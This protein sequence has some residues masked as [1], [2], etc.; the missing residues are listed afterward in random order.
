MTLL[1]QTKSK[2]VVGS[3]HFS[4]SS[5]PLHVLGPVK[6]IVVPVIVVTV[7]GGAFVVRVHES[8]ITGHDSDTSGM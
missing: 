7:I 8:H 6:V 1:V 2:S 3:L 5:T 4:S